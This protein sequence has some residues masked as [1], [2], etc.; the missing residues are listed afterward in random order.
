M[1]GE[2]YFGF[3]LQSNLKKLFALFSWFF[4]FSF[5]KRQKNDFDQ[6]YILSEWESTGNTW[7]VV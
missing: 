6:T 3:E 7:T 2:E 5:K 4:I 1:L